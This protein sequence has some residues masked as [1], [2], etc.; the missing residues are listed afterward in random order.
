MARNR[1]F[2]FVTWNVRGLNSRDKCVTVKSFIKG[3][4]CGVVCLQETKLAAISTEKFLSFCGFHIRD[5][6]VLDAVG[7]KGGIITAWNPALFD[8]EHSWTGAF[9]VNTVLKRRID[10]SLFT[11][12]NIYGPSCASL[13]GAFFQELRALGPSTLG[14]WAMLGDF[15]ITLSLRDK[16]G[17][18]SSV[19]DFLSFRSVVNDLGLI[20]L[21]IPNRRFTWTNA[22][23]NPTLVRLDRVLTCRDWLLLFPRSS[24]RAIPRPCSDHRHSFS[25]LTLS[26]LLIVSSDSRRPGLGSRVQER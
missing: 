24:L 19:P 25:Q 16:V 3:C 1:S 14:V 26:C 15:N 21:P 20:D 10:G 22:R 5:F 13:R 11:I 6:W 23:P 8:C 9:S 7:T 18:P 17:P 12:L 4:K 2:R